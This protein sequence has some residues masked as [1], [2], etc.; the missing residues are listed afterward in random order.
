MQKLTIKDIAAM[1]GVSP[2]AVSFVLNDKSG[3]SE[4][5]RQKVLEV[6]QKTNFKPNLN[7]KRLLFQKSFNIS[8]VIKQNSSPFHDLFYFEITKGVLE[9]SKEYGYNIVFTDI[10]FD[11][12]KAVLPEIIEHNDTDG[13]IFFQDTEPTIRNEVEKRNIP[14]VVVDV[15][16][17]SEDFTYVRA[18]YQLSA[19]T[20]TRYL[21]E[22]G[23][24]AIA[25][26]CS[27]F[28]P[29]FYLNIVTGYTNALKET[30]TPIPPHWIQADAMDEQTAYQCMEN[31]LKHKDSLPTAV[32]CAGDVYAIGAMKCIKNHGYHIPS[33]ISVVGLDDILLSSYVEPPLTTIAIDKFHMGS[34]ALELLVRKI[35]GESA[36]GITVQSDL[37]IERASVRNCL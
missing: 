34:E 26:I 19:Y 30:N 17:S 36:Q 22:K 37:L 21:C 33:D 12:G 28:I 27:S 20:A 29:D 31:I 3:V 24:Q 18:D 13:V 16:S 6:I 7:S 2:T 4:D 8:L 11:N 5:T 15:H 9:K 23:H 35:N 14:Y 32:F 25:L 1:A 10:A